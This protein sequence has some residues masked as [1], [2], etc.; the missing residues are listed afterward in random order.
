MVESNQTSNN[1]NQPNG[2]QNNGRPY[3]SMYWVYIIGTWAFISLLLISIFAPH[4]T[5]RL[6]FFVT[7]LWVLVTAFAVIAQAIIYRKQWQIMQQQWEAMNEGLRETRISRELENRPW[8]MVIA[9]NLARPLKVGEPPIA[10]LT[11]MNK[12]NT[13]AIGVRIRSTLEIR[14]IPVPNPAPP[15]AVFGNISV[16]II[17]PHSEAASFVPRR[18]A[19]SQAELNDIGAMPRSRKQ[20]YI[21]GVLEYRD[22]F[23]KPHNTGYCFVYQFD[24]THFAACEHSNYMDQE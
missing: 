22:V 21:W 13:P 23:G 10:A 18:A 1:A 2:G 17:A 16:P 5:E 4:M 14:D 8:L 9:L 24:S 7:T 15:V 3:G 11:L 19:L 12:G 6:K 20:I